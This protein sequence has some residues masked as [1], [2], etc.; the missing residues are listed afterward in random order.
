[1]ARQVDRPKWITLIRQVN[2]EGKICFAREIPEPAVKPGP[3]GLVMAKV[4]G[5]LMQFI[6]ES[7][8]FPKI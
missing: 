8:K 7:V 1:M 2:A 4:G 6:P 3:A 5:F